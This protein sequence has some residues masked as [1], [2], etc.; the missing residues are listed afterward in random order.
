MWNSFI[1]LFIYLFIT[2]FALCSDIEENLSALTSRRVKR[3]AAGF[4]FNNYNNFHDVS[5][6]GYNCCS[7][8]TALT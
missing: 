3:A 1:Y 6:D 2:L 4:D 7:S 8:L 5:I